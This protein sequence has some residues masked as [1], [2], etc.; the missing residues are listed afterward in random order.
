MLLCD[1]DRIK[2]RDRLG[3][4]LPFLEDSNKERIT[5]LDLMTHQARFQPFIGFYL[6]TMEPLDSGKRMLSQRPDTLYSIYLGPGSY[7]NN[8]TRFKD[9]YYASSENGLHQLQVANGMYVVSSYRDTVFYGIRDSRLLSKKQYRYSDLG[10]IL[11]TDLVEHV[12]GWPLEEFVAANFY[13]PLG[14]TSLG[15][16]PLKHF[17]E[18]R[19]VPTANDTVFRHQWLQGHVHDENAA[20]MGGVSGHAGLFGNANDLAKLM[21]MYMNGGVY[22]GE[23]YIE[24][25]TVEQFT[26]SPFHRSG[27]RRGIGFDKPEPLPNSQNPISRMASRKSFGHTGFTGTYTWADPENGLLYIFLSNRV[28]PYPTN[29]KMITTNLRTKIYEVFVRAIDD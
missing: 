10:F 16:R 19:V 6:S 22:G 9:S 7:L 4:Y 1:Q 23:R 24:E 18:G 12:S 17:P 25:K 3:E 2:L 27:N 13:K 15:Y 21:Q 28:C 20:L 8:R 26:S 11:L 5:L 14:A 29:N